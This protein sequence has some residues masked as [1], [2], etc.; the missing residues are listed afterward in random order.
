MSAGWAILGGLSQHE[1]HLQEE[2]LV[3]LKSGGCYQL[4]TINY[5][6]IFKI[7]R[8]PSNSQGLYV[9]SQYLGLSLPTEI[10]LSQDNL[11]NLQCIVDIIMCHLCRASPHLGGAHGSV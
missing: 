3:L 4:G 9:A 6:A 2:K 1:C 7:Q 8:L 10:K 11:S 5:T